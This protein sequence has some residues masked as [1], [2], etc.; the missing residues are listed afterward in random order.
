MPLF[1]SIAITIPENRVASQARCGVA[2][3]IAAKWVLANHGVDFR[4]LVPRVGVVR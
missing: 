2:L 4:D 1:W 3:T